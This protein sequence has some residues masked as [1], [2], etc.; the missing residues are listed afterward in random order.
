[1]ALILQGWTEP[2]CLIGATNPFNL[3]RFFTQI[4]L[5]YKI[6]VFLPE[7]RN[8]SVYLKI[9]HFAHPLLCHSSSHIDYPQRAK[10]LT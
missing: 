9:F 1:L 8:S 6:G 5:L 7:G 3:G 2:K 4:M 10:D